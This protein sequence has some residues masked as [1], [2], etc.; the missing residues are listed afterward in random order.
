MSSP[1]PQAR[2]QACSLERF[3]GPVSGAGGAPSPTAQPAAAHF[4]ASPSPASPCSA[5]NWP[6]R[7]DGAC[8]RDLDSLLAASLLEPFKCCGVPHGPRAT[9]PTPP[10]SAAAQPPCS[11]V[12][13]RPSCHTRRRWLVPRSR[14]PS[15]PT[16]PLRETLA[17]AGRSSRFGLPV[18]AGLPRASRQRRMC[19]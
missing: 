1:D 18:L 8:S 13:P 4:M 3:P 11:V 12:G 17:K 9:P 7:A 2:S 16:R 6:L 5:S 14:S 19:R 10:S 15:V